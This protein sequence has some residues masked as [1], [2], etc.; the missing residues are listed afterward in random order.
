MCQNNEPGKRYFDSTADDRVV[1]IAS[2]LMLGSI[3]S[4]SVVLGYLLTSQSLELLRTAQIIANTRQESGSCG[5]IVTEDAIGCKF[6]II[7]GEVRREDRHKE[8]RAQRCS[9]TDLLHL[10]SLP[11]I[12][13][14][15]NDQGTMGHCS[16]KYGL[17][18]GR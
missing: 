3:R 15:A 5:S 12:A 17:T 7:L 13:R 1:Q 9:R 8:C 11:V 2:Y 18:P 6:E 4:L 16:A 14:I 10:Y